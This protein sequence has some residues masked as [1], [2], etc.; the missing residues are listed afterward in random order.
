MQEASAM[1]DFIFSK[2]AEEQMLRRGISHKIVMAVMSQ[3]EETLVDDTTIM[4]FQSLIKEENR[5]FLLRIFVNES[6]TPHEIITLYKTS[7]I[8]KYYESEIR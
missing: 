7:K 8:K 4:I 5:W 1:N 6:K 2:H 3:P